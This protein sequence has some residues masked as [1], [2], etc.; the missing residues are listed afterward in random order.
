MMWR[1]AGLL[2][3]VVTVFAACNQAGKKKFEVS[4]LI[5]NAPAL[6]VY[7][8]EIPASRNIPPQISD[9]A[10][11]RD[12]KFLLKAT[13]NEEAMY[14]I[15]IGDEQDAPILF[16]LND[17][18]KIE[19]KADWQK[20]NDRSSNKTAYTVSSPANERLIMFFD[21]L[22]AFSKQQYELN[23]R[24]NQIKE[25]ADTNKDSLLNDISSKLKE[26]EPAYSAY[27]INIAKTDKSPVIALYALGYWSGNNK[28]DEIEIQFKEL[29][30]RFP[31]HKG[32][33]L[34]YDEFE[35]Q[36]SSFKKQQ[37]ADKNKPGIGKTAPDITMPDVNGNNFSL[38]SLK[39]KYVLVD[40][41]ASWCAPCRAENPNIVNVYN[42][43]RDKNFTIL[44]VSLDDDKE[45]WKKAIADDKLPWMQVSDLKNWESPVARQYGFNAIPYNVLVDP[46]GTIIATGLRGP[47]LEARLAELIK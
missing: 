3:T 4:G 47:S 43:F 16:V 11:I 35:K 26:L 37:E 10:M 41:W 22:T 33:K 1:I 28:P 25:S 5:S 2:L 42:K 31:A 29:L 6:K 40:F 24:A 18:N 8:E 45:R 36:Y 46:S 27:L 7:L 14:R 39:G 17:E 12:G 15:R 44:G 30:K 21:S 34:G 32:V 20:L 23:T 38:S 9:T 19:I 13:A